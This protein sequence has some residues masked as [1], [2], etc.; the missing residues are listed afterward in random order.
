VDTDILNVRR[1]DTTDSAQGGKVA[2]RS[3]EW[4]ALAQRAANI[5]SWDWDIP[6]GTLYWSDLIEPMFG[7][8]HGGFGGT[9]EDFLV[10][11]HPADRE[12]VVDA[13][14]A[15][16]VEGSDYAIEHRVVWPDGTVRWVSEVGDVIRDE[17]GVATRMLGVVQDI[18]DRKM[19]QEALE[20]QVRFNKAL[21][22]LSGALLSTASMNEIS[23][24]VLDHA[25]HLT[26]SE[27][28]YVAH[29]DPE[30]GHLVSTT[31]T[32]T[33]WDACQVEEKT[34][35]FKE[36]K[37][38]WGWVMENKEPLLTNAPADDPRSSGTPKGHVPIRNFLAVPATIGDQ[39]VGEIALANTGDGFD[40]SDLTSVQRLADL[41]AIAL[42]RHWSELALEQR[43]VELQ[44]RND[45]LDAYAHM[46]A[47][48]L[49]NPLG[50][51]VG[52]AEALSSDHIGMA[53]DEEE[54]YLDL[55]VQN[56]HR[57]IKIIDELL[58]LT[59]V[60]KTEVKLQPLDMER[61]LAEAQQEL[62]SLI[63]EYRAEIR[64]PS[65]WPVALGHAPWIERV[66]VNYLSNAIKYGGRPPRV[67][68]GALMQADGMARFWV[69]D[70]GPGLGKVERAQ[71]FTP[72]AQFARD[73]VQGHG[74]GLSIVRRIVEKLGGQVGVQ[75]D[76]VPGGG[77]LFTFTL[78]TAGRGG[79]SEV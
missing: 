33:V 48:D 32:G 70:N 71:L 75:S 26:G 54:R 72:F 51:V 22:D 49:K 21:A 59:R 43:T 65:S 5:G 60:R 41:Y 18:T 69:R 61:I 29:V 2:K 23:N 46:V 11:V 67:E 47:H 6:S 63:E 40:G 66:W 20:W 30:T 57:V 24:L 55:I 25:R 77:S 38:L 42:Q 27:F 58:I 53:A 74:L 34:I 68:V 17:N 50:L 37:G 52:F 3:E 4:Y 79:D 45:E 7:F 73:R 56:G 14:S 8:R 9:Y 28:G 19:A 12:F 76:G 36:F 35:I 1:P 39:L 10:C 62:S 64:L 31:L 78:Q 44:A 15:C 16:L 13:V